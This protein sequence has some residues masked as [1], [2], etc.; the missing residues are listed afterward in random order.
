MYKKLF[1]TLYVY[2]NFNILKKYF[3]TFKLLWKA[4]GAWTYLHLSDDIKNLW[5]YTFPALHMPSWHTYGKLNVTLLHLNA[6][7]CV[8][9]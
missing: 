5:Y 2:T 8:C 1:Q 9:L 6:A 7:L 4:A 3:Y